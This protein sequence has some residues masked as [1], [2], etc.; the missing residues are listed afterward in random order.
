MNNCFSFKRHE[1]N[2]RTDGL[3]WQWYEL[4]FLDENDLAVT[5][6]QFWDNSEIQNWIVCTESVNNF[7]MVH[8]DWK[9]KKWNILAAQV[10]YL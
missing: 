3:F 1:S 10:K 8:L 4:S 7:L 5:L 2:N 6:S 9:R